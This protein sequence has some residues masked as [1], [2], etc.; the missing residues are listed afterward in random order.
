MTTSTT[1]TVNLV[2]KV[3]LALRRQ[4]RAAA[5]M[6]G[7]T[8]SDV[9]RQALAEY[10]ARVEE[11]DDDAAYARRVLA[12]VE[13]GA[14]TFDHDEVWAELEALEVAGELPA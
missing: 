3:P 10:V 13:A 12:R 1:S 2:V 5:V 7:E 11:E 8:I 4:A 6:R 14:P 9:V